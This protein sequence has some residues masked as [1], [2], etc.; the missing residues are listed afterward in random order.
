MKQFVRY[1]LQFSLCGLNCALCTMKLDGYCPGCG[2]GDGNQGCS[3]ARCSIEH[4]KI[5]YCCECGEYPCDR[6]NNIELYDSFIT[7]RRQLGDMQRIKKDGLESYH[8][9]LEEKAKLLQK[10]LNSCN[11]GRHKTFFFLAVNLLELSDLKTVMNIIECE[12]PADATVKEKAAIAQKYFED[13]AGLRGVT[14]KLN[15]KPTK[16]K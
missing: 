12:I 5:E 1:D 14:L 3:I 4:G 15:K 7:H 11:D 6:Y 9:M 13:M 16:S 8:A 10:L 2:G